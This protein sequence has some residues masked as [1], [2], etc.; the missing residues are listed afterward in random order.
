MGDDSDYT[1]PPDYFKMIFGSTPAKILTKGAQLKDQ[2]KYL[3]SR[4]DVPEQHANAIVDHFWSHQDPEAPF[5]EWCAGSVR[6]EY[7]CSDWISSRYWRWRAG[8]YV[9][10]SQREFFATLPDLESPWEKAKL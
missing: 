4:Q 6:P 10:F 7:C 2:V 8:A 9:P 3:L 5:P 1:T